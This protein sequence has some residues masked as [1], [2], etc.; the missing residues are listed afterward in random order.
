[1][2]PLHFACYANAPLYVIQLLVRT[3]GDALQEDHV[4]DGYGGI[5]NPH[6]AL[7][8]A[9]DA[10]APLEVIQYLVDTISPCSGRVVDEAQ[11]IV[12]E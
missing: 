8:L 3:W 4:Y 12:I 1:M 10:N 7:I 2:Y 6:G 5:N 9:C 11:R